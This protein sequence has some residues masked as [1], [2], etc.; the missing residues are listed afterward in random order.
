MS[1]FP[2]PE[3]AAQTVMYQ[4]KYG[5]GLAAGKA[6]QD[7][8]Y[9]IGS[10][11]SLR[12]APRQIGTQS[13]AMRREARRLRKQGY[14]AQAGQMAGAAA[15][16][17]LMEGSAIK[18]ERQRGVETAQQIQA[19]RM[20]QEQQDM[21]RNYTKLANRLL[22]KQYDQL[23][24]PDSGRGNLWEPTPAAGDSPKLELQTDRGNLFDQPKMPTMDSGIPESAADEAYKDMEGYRPY[25]D[26]RK[27]Q[28]MLRKKLLG[29]SGT[30]PKGN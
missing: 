16:Q 8:N 6:M 13:G 10:G 4:R 5:S 15:Q 23:N 20:A 7:E 17:K 18:S 9:V 28:D 12:E 26:Y 1:M 29:Q 11:S 24:E 21:S 30:K 27:E 14:T 3:E 22:Q 25:S 2:S 19:G